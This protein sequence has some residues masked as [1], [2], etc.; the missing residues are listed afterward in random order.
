M[1]HSA[2]IYR[3]GSADYIIA[4]CYKAYI[5]ATTKDAFYVYSFFAYIL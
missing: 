5:E 4:S 1:S 2:Y 3:Y